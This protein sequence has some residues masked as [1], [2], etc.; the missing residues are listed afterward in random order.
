MIDRKNLIIK[1]SGKKKKTKQKLLKHTLYDK[2]VPLPFDL[3]KHYILQGFPLFSFAKSNGPG[4]H[5]LPG[6]QDDMQ[7]LFSQVNPKHGKG[8]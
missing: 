5:S 8:T 6:H 2:T 4:I 7:D 1:K 3:A